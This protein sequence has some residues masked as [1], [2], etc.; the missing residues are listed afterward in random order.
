[1]STVPVYRAGPLGGL[2][3]Q[4]GRSAGMILLCRGDGVG[5]ST[6]FGVESPA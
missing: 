3:G 4:E 2:G 1:M 5:V 6:E